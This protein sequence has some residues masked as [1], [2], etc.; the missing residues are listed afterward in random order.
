MAAT[1]RRSLATDASAEP[2]R[3]KGPRPWGAAELSTTTFWTSA[4]G[5]PFPTYR[6]SPGQRTNIVRMF[7]TSTARWLPHALR[8]G[9]WGYDSNSNTSR[10]FASSSPSTSYADVGIMQR[11]VSGVLETERPR[12]P[13]SRRRAF[14][15][16]PVVLSR[17]AVRTGDCFQP[18]EYRP[19]R[20]V[21]LEVSR[22]DGVRLGRSAS[23][24]SRPNKRILMGS[25]GV[26]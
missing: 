20:A 19:Q 13:T 12:R 10:R 22:E 1:H 3:L 21:E 9:S 4:H 2:Q 5:Y 18:L 11:G 7:L 6:S 16:H 8:L 15:I 24:L 23:C 17:C 26:R 14:R 25:R